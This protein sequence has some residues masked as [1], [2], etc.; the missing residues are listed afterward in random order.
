MSPISDT[1]AMI[2]RFAGEIAGDGT[3]RPPVLR[4]RLW[5]AVFT[6]AMTALALTVLLFDPGSGYSATLRSE[7]FYRKLVCMLLLAGGAFHLVRNAARP[8][9]TRPG[10]AA[11][12]PAAAA[13]ALGGILDGSGLSWTGRSEWSVPLC[14]GSI[15]LLSMPAFAMILGVLRTGA[16]TRPA[17]AGASVGLFAGALGAA[18]Y[19][20]VC[21]ND[22]GLFVAAWYGTAVLIMAGLGAAAGSRLLRW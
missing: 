10:F 20:L 9:S 19:A 3:R 1:D 7:P 11:L 17:A 16:P 4:R 22:A 5:F 2:R 12:L 8:D 15:V 6:S 14:V 13:I 21:R 18:A